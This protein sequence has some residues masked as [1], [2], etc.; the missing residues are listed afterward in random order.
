MSIFNDKEVNWEQV[1]ISK[2]LYDGVGMAGTPEQ[3][4][5]LREYFKRSYHQR[6]VDSFHRQS[7]LVW[8]EKP[9]DL[10]KVDSSE[11]ILRAKLILEEALETIEA[12]GLSVA[13]NLGSRA[14]G[15]TT[16]WQIIEFDALMISKIKEP[17][18]VKFVDGCF[19]LRV[20]TTG[21]LSQFGIPDS[22]QEIVDQNNLLKVKTGTINEHGKLIKAANHPSPE[23]ELR[24]WL[25]E[26]GWC[27]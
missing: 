7:G 23:P 4:D 12:L 10:T 21:S 11:L 15:Q 20:V 19:D 27:N 25:I 14:E 13:L 3:R 24:S 8:R 2:T 6:L 5:L 1:F 26:C 18:I 9:V 16:K 17:D 22:G